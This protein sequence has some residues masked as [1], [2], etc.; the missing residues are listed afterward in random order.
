MSDLNTLKWDRRFLKLAKL[1]ASWSKDPST[2]TGAVLVASDR[3]ILSVGYN[4]FPKGMN[5]SEKLYANRET[6][7]SRIVHCEM[8][9]ILN[10]KRSVE[11]STLYTWPL[12][13]CDRCVVHMIQAGVKTFVF[14]ALPKKLRKRWS[15][16][17]W[18]TK[19]YIEEA[20][21][22]WREI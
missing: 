17:L 15:E 18:R 1:V 5:D 21:L 16:S 11:G 22:Y 3:T 14:P 10:A 19:T 20:K 9:A 6:K 7:Y 8:N 12:G 2:Q 4:G 13:S